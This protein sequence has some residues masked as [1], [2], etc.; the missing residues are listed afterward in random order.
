MRRPTQLLVAVILLALALGGGAFF[1][2]G[3][4]TEWF[5]G[6]SEAEEQALRALG[7]LRA[8][9]E[10]GITYEEYTARLEDVRL[11]VDRSLRMMAAQGGSESQHAVELAMS[12]Y[13]AA[14]W[15]WQAS[16][17][18]RASN[19]L[20]LA[21]HLPRAGELTLCPAVR[22]VLAQADKE[23]KHEE[24]LAIDALNVGA[25]WTCAAG[26]V[27]RAER[28]APAARRW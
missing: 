5:T 10:R 15:A 18:P 4:I 13:L 27:A 6:R 14:G 7:A 21:Q 11:Q 23:R 20:I 22:L 19:W 24:T 12:Y 1:L 25:F 28:L 26:Q 3:T 17:M 9:T 16:L 2:A 8:L